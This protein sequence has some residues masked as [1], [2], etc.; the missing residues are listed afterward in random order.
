MQRKSLFIALMLLSF[1]AAQHCRC[2]AL[3]LLSF[4]AA[5]FY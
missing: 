2:S 5:Q 4:A 1:A 3:P